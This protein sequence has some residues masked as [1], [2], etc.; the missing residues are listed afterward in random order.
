MAEV[1]VTEDWQFNHQFNKPRLSDPEYASVSDSVSLMP[2]VSLGVAR[3][4]LEA[5]MAL[6]AEKRSQP[7]DT[8]LRDDPYVQAEL[9]RAAALLGAARAYLY[10]ALA[11]HW[12]A[13]KA[14]DTPTRQLRSG[15]R[16]AT[17]YAVTASLQVVDA[18]HALAGSSAVYAR[19]PLERYFRDVHTAATHVAMRAPQAY[20]TGGQLLLDLEPR[21]G[22]F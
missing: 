16:L 15:L 11:E 13:V 6:A 4:A 8:L 17:A 9:G 19:N 10:Q 21:R 22:Y 3:A 7:G 18:M 1:L 2:A 14:G 20:V 5:M 12:S